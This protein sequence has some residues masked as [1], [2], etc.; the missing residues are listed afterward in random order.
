MSQRQ[1][2]IAQLETIKQLVQ[3]NTMTKDEYS[4]IKQRVLTLL[5]QELV[6]DLERFSYPS[7]EKKTELELLDIFSLEEWIKEQ[8]S[9]ESR[10]ETLRLRATKVHVSVELSPPYRSQDIA[11]ATQKIEEGEAH[12][13]RCVVLEERWRKIGYPIEYPRTIGSGALDI[14]EEKCQKQEEYWLQ[15][16]KIR[17]QYHDIECD[18]KDLSF[19]IEE[20]QLTQYKEK[21]AFTQKW[22]ETID[23][24]K[25]LLIPSYRNRISFPSAPFSEKEIVEYSANVK[26]FL[27][28]SRLIRYS[29]PFMLLLISLGLVGTML[30]ENQDMD[31]TVVVTPPTKP[32]P[33]PNPIVVT[34]PTKPNPQSIPYAEFTISADWDAL[35]FIDGKKINEVP[36]IKHQ[37]SPGKHTIVLLNKKKERKEEVVDL[38]RG[39]LY[40]YIWSYEEKTW[41][42]KEISL[43]SKQSK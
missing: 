17:K 12:W 34:P 11:Y 19:P 38:E 16:Q 6:P 35:V 41:S 4:V 14:E 26:P 24:H 10:I 3:N 25:K 42:R 20:S 13:A 5:W 39:F 22:K 28:R 21:F 18:V 7:I 33:Q 1:K 2:Y 37:L 30:S 40:T 36:V 31:S 32:N 15:Y 43:I 9:Y 27:R 23:Q 29:V 8:K